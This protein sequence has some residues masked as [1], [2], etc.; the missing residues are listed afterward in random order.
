MVPQPLGPQTRMRPF[1]RPGSNKWAVSMSPVSPP[2]GL[3]AYQAAAA[4][5]L[6]AFVGVIVFVA[7]NVAGPTAALV[8]S[9]LAV[10]SGLVPGA[11]L[12]S[13]GTATYV[14]GPAWTYRGTVLRGEAFTRLEAVDG[15]F[16]LAERMVR[17]IPTGVRWDDVAEDVEVLRWEALEHAF[18]LAAL[19][20]Q[21]VELR[22]A[23][24]GTALAALRKQIRDKRH[25]HIAVLQSIERDAEDLG[26]VAANA[27]AT[28]EIALQRTGSLAALQVAAPSP[29]AIAARANL[30]ELRERLS[31]L[32]DVWTELDETHTLSAA[33]AERTITSERSDR[34][35]LGRGRRRPRE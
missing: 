18:A 1:I 30:A 31:L 32:A 11:Y 4:A 27:A 13:R 19:D 7:W 22:Y 26:S 15:R 10:L 20:A 14:A 2:A 24:T 33:E 16:E 3:V 17:R 5:A 9:A 8:A 28:A 21:L 6:V 35:E 23:P 34:R 29:R 25:E 12:M